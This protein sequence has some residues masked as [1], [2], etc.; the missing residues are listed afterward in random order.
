MTAVWTALLKVTPP[1]LASIFGGIL[2][3][4][5][6]EGLRLTGLP[7]LSLA[8][9]GLKVH[10]CVGSALSYG[11]MSASRVSIPSGARRLSVFAD[12]SVVSNNFRIV[13]ALE[14]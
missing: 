5:I 9:S 7:L 11:W 8:S 10:F 14:F 3:W 6:S 12:L 1:A 4:L 13:Y 2:L